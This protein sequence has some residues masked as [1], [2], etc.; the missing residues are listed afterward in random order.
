MGKP[1]RS[2]TR[3]LL[4]LS[5]SANVLIACY[6]AGKYWYYTHSAF[7]LRHGYIHLTNPGK[8]QW[9]DFIKSKADTGEIIFAGTSITQGFPLMEAFNNPHIKNLGFG[10]NQTFNVLKQVKIYIS[11]KPKK[12]FL[13]VGVNDFKR[14]VSLDSAYRNFVEICA[15]VKTKSPLTQLYVQSVLPTAVDQYNLLVKAYN[16]KVADYCLQNHI[17]YINL[18]PDFLK[19]TRLNRGL[20]LDGMHPNAAG[21]F[22]WHRDIVR[23]VLQ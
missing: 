8:K 7:L 20:S 23:Y 3:I 11:R 9:T 22:L 10:Y 6:F 21:Y 1:A 19:G 12:I 2:I 5:L 18:Y 4:I 16:H 17:T 15:T 14:G 13:E